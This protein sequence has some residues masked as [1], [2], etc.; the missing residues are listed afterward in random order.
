MDLDVNWLAII[1]ATALHQA[2]GA[3]WYGVLFKKL[4]LNEMGDV[5]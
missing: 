2:L 3:L 1:T 4:W 5:G